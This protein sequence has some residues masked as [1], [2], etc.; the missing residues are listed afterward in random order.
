MPYADPEQ[1]RACNRRSYAKHAEKNRASKRRRKAAARIRLKEVVSKARGVP[2]ADCGHSYPPVCMDFDHVRGKKLYDV[3]TIVANT[4][5]M[6]TLLAE[7][8]KCEV[9]C[10][11]CHRLR[12]QGRL[13][14]VA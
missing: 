4:L 7:I 5:S 14:V 3:A 12:T 10:A 8:A 2:C 9:V 1:A 13:T 6:K 11:N